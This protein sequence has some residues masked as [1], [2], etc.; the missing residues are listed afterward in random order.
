MRIVTISDLHG[1]D[2]WQQINPKIYDKL[3]FL[4]DYVDAPYRKITDVAQIDGMN[5]KVL[6]HEEHGRTNA[7]ILYNLTKIIELKDEYPSKVVLL[8]GNHDVP[9]IYH[10]K[11]K[12]S[13]LLKHVLYV[14]VV[15][16]LK[17]MLFYLLS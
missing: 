10:I 6:V 16:E 17:I 8:L 7:E 15:H 3:I 13:L 4:G 9:Y 2:V 5:N 12:F 11:N 1:K 14:E